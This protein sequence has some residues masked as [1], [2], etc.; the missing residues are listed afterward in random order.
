[1]RKLLLLLPLILA[2]PVLAE[3]DPFG[4]NEDAFDMYKRHWLNFEQ[5]SLVDH[6]EMACS[7]LRMASTVLKIHFS[8]I[9]QIAPDID[10]FK[11]RE[12]DRKFLSELCTPYGF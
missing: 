4:L 6:W 1:M 9:Q 12:S 5:F 2:T 7:E 3:S 8:Q 11:S 10:W